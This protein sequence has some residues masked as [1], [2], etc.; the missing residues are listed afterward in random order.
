VVRVR[1]HSVVTL[2][3]MNDALNWAREMNEVASKRGW[4]TSRVLMPG[5]GKVNGLIMETEFP[6]LAAMQKHDEAFY[7]DAEMMK[8]FRRGTDFNA[9]GSHPWDELEI[10]APQ[11]L[12]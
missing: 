6:D 3:K 4:P 7:S 12:A 10:E 5:F 9:P 1:F 11:Q 2:G 8:V